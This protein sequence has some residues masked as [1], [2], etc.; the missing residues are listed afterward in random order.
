MHWLLSGSRDL[1]PPA[2]HDCFC[3][4]KVPVGGNYTTC[5]REVACPVCLALGLGQPVWILNVSPGDLRALNSTLRLQ[6]G[7]TNRQRDRHIFLH[8]HS[9][10]CSTVC[11]NEFQAGPQGWG[12]GLQLMAILGTTKVVVIV[13]CPVPSS[14]KT[15]ACPAQFM[16]GCR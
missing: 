2:G 3:I 7:H 4:Y 16:S 14:L 11:L 10:L 5:E 12:Y 13:L 9:F 6:E 15:E 1:A 8:A